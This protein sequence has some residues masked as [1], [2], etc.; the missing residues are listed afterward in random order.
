MTFHLIHHPMMDMGSRSLTGLEDKTG[1]ESTNGVKGRNE[2]GSWWAL[3]ERSV[4]VC[5][6]VCAHGGAGEKCGQD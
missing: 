5:V 4:C 1:V 6:C 2:E 3:A